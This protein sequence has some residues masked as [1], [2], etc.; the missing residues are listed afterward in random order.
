MLLSIK[1]G[2]PSYH[3]QEKP[4]S[5][6]EVSRTLD[7]ACFECGFIHPGE[8]LANVQVGTL[9]ASRDSYLELVTEVDDK[10][11]PSGLNA[12]PFSI[13]ASYLKASRLVLGKDSECRR[14]PVC[15]KP[16]GTVGDRTRRVVVETYAGRMVGEVL[17]KVV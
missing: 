6:R 11:I 8:D 3:P 17:V 5:G 12:Y 14:V 1:T 10:S 9:E 4:K 15:A 13:F 7:C 16:Q 2:I